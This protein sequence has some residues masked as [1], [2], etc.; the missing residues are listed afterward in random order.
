[1]TPK[2]AYQILSR[3]LVF[4]ADRVQKAD[5]NK[6]LSYDKAESAALKIALI[7]LEDRYGF[8]QD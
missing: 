1:M 6:D 4:L 2:K 3:R 8:S 7:E 5:T